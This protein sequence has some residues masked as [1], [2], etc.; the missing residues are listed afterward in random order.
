MTQP[1]ELRA[2]ARAAA[3]VSE[4]CAGAQ[5]CAAWAWRN[6]PGC[7]GRRAGSRTGEGPHLDGS[8]KSWSAALRLQLPMTRACRPQS[9]RCARP[10]RRAVDLI[11]NQPGAPAGGRG[12]GVAGR[13]IAARQGRRAR[14][15]GNDR[16][17]GAHRAW[18]PASTAAPAC[19]CTPRS[20]APGRALGGPPARPHTCR[21][22][23]SGCGWR[24]AA[25]AAAGP[26]RRRPSRAPG[27]A[28]PPARQ[29]WPR[30]GRAAGRTAGAQPAVP[31]LRLWGRGR[32][33][34]L[35][36]P[37]LT[38]PHVPYSPL[39]SVPVH[40]GGHE[41]RV[42]CV[43][44]P[45]EEHFKPSRSLSNRLVGA[46]HTR[47]RR[48]GALAAALG[49]HNSKLRGCAPRAGHWVR[50]SPV[51]AARSDRN[52]SAT[53]VRS[54]AARIS[55][56]SPGYTRPRPPQRVHCSDACRARECRTATCPTPFV[57]SYRAAH[58]R[59]L[60][61]LRES[62]WRGASRKAAAAQDAATH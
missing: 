14:A 57:S 59:R 27:A 12:A 32:P 41:P 39:L 25:S 30:S 44:R 56:A 3:P 52:C 58:D 40:A 7:E 21:R 54:G 19:R 26:G 20:A 47:P 53:G 10:C 22:P 34:G 24:T 31:A 8:L 13:W 4:P 51:A 33:R 18:A 6:A 49:K 37:R 15:A 45:P 23:R 9:W 42:P 29:R 36:G 5:H 16:V 11:L 2:R 61:S 50:S 62:E 46:H 38:G 17:D 48:A 43:L 35:Q 28:R 60:L 55:E 1:A